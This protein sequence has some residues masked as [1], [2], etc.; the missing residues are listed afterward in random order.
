M[1]SACSTATLD[2][3]GHRSSRHVPKSTV[4]SHCNPI[5]CCHS[6]G[7]SMAPRPFGCTSLF[8]S[9]LLFNS[10]PSAAKF[11]PQ[12]SRLSLHCCPPQPFLLLQQSSLLT[13]LLLSVLFGFSTSSLAFSHPV[14]NKLPGRFLKKANLI[15]SLPSLE[16]L[17]LLYCS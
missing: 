14:L 5:S 11:T 1:Y 7:H 10:S 12:Y 15:V 3:F 6:L 2:A 9:P 13:G 8:L 16:P 4:N 17:M